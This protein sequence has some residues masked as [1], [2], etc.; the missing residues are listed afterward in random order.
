MRLRSRGPVTTYFAAPWIDTPQERTEAA[1][2]F[3]TWGRSWH[4]FV[5]PGRYTHLE[6]RKG[7][8]NGMARWQLDRLWREDVPALLFAWEGGPLELRYDCAGRARGL[9]L[10][11][12]AFDSGEP[13]DID[14][15][16]TERGTVRLGGPGYVWV[17]SSPAGDWTLKVA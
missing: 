16:G 12:H 1:A 4:P 14:V 3:H 13:L 2:L 17:H 5:L 9:G 15:T 7:G 8:E 10:V 6:V 11:H